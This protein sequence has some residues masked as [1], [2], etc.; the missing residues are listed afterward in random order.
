MPI[1]TANT[2]DVSDITLLLVDDEQ[3]YLDSLQDSL[4][5]LVARTYTAIDGEAALC[6]AHNQKVDIAIIDVRL[7]NMSGLELLE[8]L[9]ALHR[10]TVVVMLSGY[11]DKDLIQNGLRLGLYDFIDKPFDQNLIRA[12]L[13]RYIEKVKTDRYLNLILQ[14]LLISSQLADPETFNSMPENERHRSLEALL[15]LVRL[16]KLKSPEPM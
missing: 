13:M 10:N 6:I 4:G 11:G 3:I 7:P 16:K 12:A 5:D 8:E 2:D 15:G 9:K 1:S 14:E